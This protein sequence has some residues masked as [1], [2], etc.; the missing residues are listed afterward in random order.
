MLYRFSSGCGLVA[1][2]SVTY[3]SLNEVVDG[4]CITPTARLPAISCLDLLDL[5][6]GV[7]IC[8]SVCV[9]ILDPV[10]VVDPWVRNRPNELLVPPAGI[11]FHFSYEVGTIFVG[12]RGFFLI[13]SDGSW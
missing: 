10:S 7:C 6:I 1:G 11:R 5:S 8:I 13:R 3:S 9:C 12:I 4:S 2:S